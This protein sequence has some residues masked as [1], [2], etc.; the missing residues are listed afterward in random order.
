MSEPST[1]QNRTQR[2]AP[3]VDLLGRYERTI[4][5]AVEA[6]LQEGL[7]GSYALPE[8]RERVA[9]AWREPLAIVA[10]EELSRQLAR[11]A[12]VG[13][14]GDCHPAGLRRAMRAYVPLIAVAART[15]NGSLMPAFF[16]AD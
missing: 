5:D 16:A 13:A 6:T 11:K 8:A 14:S 2:A 10:A 9:E 7:R 4:A 15:E 3:A 1:V 12:A